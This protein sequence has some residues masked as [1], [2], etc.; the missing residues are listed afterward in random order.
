MPM[1]VL[2]R[3][4]FV[5]EIFTAEFLIVFR[6]RKKKFF[7]LWFG[8]FLIG[9]AAL[10]IAIPLIYNA[11]YTIC[12]FIAIFAVTIPMLK[13]SCEISWKNVVFCGVAAYTMQ[14]FG[15]GVANIFTTVIEG[16]VNMIFG[17]Y[18]QGVLNITDI[19][20]FS[21]LKGLVYITAYYVVYSFVY[22]VFVKKIERGAEFCIRS[23]AVMLVCGA[24]L[25]V[26]VIINVIVIYYVDEKNTLMLVMNAF[27]ESLC[28]VFILYIQFGLIRKGEL[29]HELDL[30]QVLLREKE[31]QY[32]LSKDNIELINFKC[33]DLR[34][35]IREIG[36]GRGLPAETV[37]E[38][39]DAISIYDAGVHTDNEVLDIILT[40]KSLK[41]ARD[42][43]A[44]TCVADG[45]SL[46]FMEKSDIY[47]L[48][49]NALDNAI[50]A[51]MQLETEKRTVG[52]IVRSVGNMVSVNIYNPFAGTLE[53]DTDGFPVTTKDNTD[54]HGFGIK[55]I[56]RIAEKYNGICTASTNNNTFVLN[57]LMSKKITE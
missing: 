24:G 38:I 28:S 29:E 8:L 52:V 54:F 22:I 46:E 55:S 27:Y 12:S 57:V 45:K 10:A 21:V 30:T 26:D 15:Y 48:F 47:S 35:Q 11:F 14:H 1:L 2:N 13:L 23:T 34:H 36:E 33:H 56:R 17:M 31:R 4:L 3:L 6:H 32:K 53:T 39:K 51:V 20:L 9:A 16:D 19:T 40:E 18:S 43:I 7:A 50:E 25:L 42:E 37:E 44:L 5:A 41:C 49:G